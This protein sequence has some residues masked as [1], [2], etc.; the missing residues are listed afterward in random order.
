MKGKGLEFVGIFVKDTET[1]ARNFVSQHKLI[2]PTGLDP[3]M[4]IAKSYKVVGPPLTIFID[5][6]GRIV[7]RVSGPMKEKDISRRVEKLTQGEVL[8]PP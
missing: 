3:D 1:N 6:D 2:F 4:K 7:E 5:K 8:S